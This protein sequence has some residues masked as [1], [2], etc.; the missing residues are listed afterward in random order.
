MAGLPGKKTKTINITVKRKPGNWLK[1]VGIL[2]GVLWAGAMGAVFAVKNMDLSPSNTHEKSGGHGEDTEK[3]ELSGVPA[4]AAPAGGSHA[5]APTTGPKKAV[6][7]EAH[8]P[9]KPAETGHVEN[10]DAKAAQAA[11]SGSP[12]AHAEG[13]AHAADGCEVGSEPA[14]TGPSSTEERDALRE[15]AEI[16]VSRGDLQKALRPLR[17]LLA[18][19]TQDAALLSLGA[20]AFH[21]TGNFREALESARK[22]LRFAAP[23]RVDLEVIAILSQYRLGQVEAAF[24][25]AE[26]ALKRHH[27]DVHLLTAVGTMEIEMGPAHPRF[28][29]SLEKALK[30]KPGHVPALYQLGRKSQLQ[31]DYKDAETLFRKVVKKEPGNAKAHGQ[32]GTALYHLRKEAEARK[33]FQ[34]ALALNPKDYNTWYNLGELCLARAAREKS[35]EKIRQ[36]RAEA[37]GAYLKS[38]EWNPDHAEAHFRIGVLLNGNGQFKEAIR[39]LEAARKVDGSHVP[40]W[41]Q[42][43]V[44][45]ENLKRPERAKACLEKALELDPR[46]K[47]VQFKLRQMT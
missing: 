8:H 36:W 46:D 38:V 11:H 44:A 43:A 13:G 7:Q 41:V 25:S 5:A 2:S 20:E 34:A 22:A 21:G 4:A 9:N 23:G 42:L 10:E 27:E 31:G 17:R 6:D 33:E 15:L 1:R 24:R 45:Y 28:G 19:P 47:I 16:H 37:M 26:A 32:L 40:T 14:V 3:A 39:H 12:A 30:I 35:A 18:E 29:K